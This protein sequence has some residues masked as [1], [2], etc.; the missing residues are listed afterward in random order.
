MDPRERTSLQTV[1][2]VAAIALLLA[3]VVAVNVHA[4]SHFYAYAQRWQA[5]ATLG[6]LDADSPTRLP[7]GQ[8]LLPH[9][10]AG[11]VMRKG[12]VFSWLCAAGLA[13][14]RTYDDWSYCLPTIAA[15]LGLGLCTYVLGRRWYTRRVG[16]LAACMLITTAEMFG[17]T[18][19]ATTDVLLGLWMALAI[20]CA[21]RLTFHPCRKGRRPWWIAGLWLSMLLA[22]WTKGWGVVNVPIIGGTFAA[23]GMFGGGFRVLRIARGAGEKLVLGGRLL[24][25]RL[26]W[27]TRAVNLW[28]L[29][30][31]L[32]ATA[33][34]LYVMYLEDPVQFPRVLEF[35]VLHRTTGSGGDPSPGSPQRVL[36]VPN[37]VYSLL[38]LS[39]FAMGSLLLVHPKRWLTRRGP[40]YLPL[41]WI[42]MTVVAFSVPNGFRPDYLL[43][44][45]P[46]MALMAAWAV[47]RLARRVQ[48]P[49]ARVRVLR[50][51]FAAV[52]VVIGVA[53]AAA[54]FA[55]WYHDTMPAF[56][57]QAMPLPT[58][59][60]E[61]T[62]AAL[63]AAVFLGVGVL[64]WG[65]IASLKWR[66]RQVAA[67][68]CV[69]ML[70]VAF[71][72]TH[73]L[74]RHARTGD[75]ETMR[76]FAAAADEAVGDDEFVTY[77]TTGVCVRV[78]MGRLGPVLSRPGTGR[79]LPI[80]V[81]WEQLHAE[82]RI[83]WL[84]T[85]DRGLVEMGQFRPLPKNAREDPEGTYRVRAMGGWWTFQVLPELLADGTVLVSDRPVEAN[86]W[87]RL[88]LI[89]LRPG[90][91]L[92]GPPLHLGYIPGEQDEGE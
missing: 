80:E 84:I 7:G 9:N 70:G 81:T 5:G 63:A 31:V 44:C 89:P 23:A 54:P 64:V 85:C 41:W 75:G 53:L 8:W 36:R 18:F 40:I 87:G 52:P 92:A 78:Y 42:I 77:Y 4:P 27:L 76:K 39:V 72:Y 91:R 69:G 61:D 16:V 90:A 28:W 66:V 59:A 1:L 32:G 67:A 20:I 48:Q 25:R 57:S 22:A 2:D 15:T 29:I 10:Q 24:M 45:Y 3:A 65:V 86:G 38:P 21:D 68:A 19:M 88:Y 51:A 14:T 17:Q 56:I 43:P 33:G 73:F 62:W 12:P 71:L 11:G 55:Y 34:L 6:M 46:A 83:R 26:W 82:R 47:D 74:S 35:E 49:A 50:H 79:A 13:A 60:G 30:A 37:L 58:I